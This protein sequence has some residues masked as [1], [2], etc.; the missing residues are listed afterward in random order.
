MEKPYGFMLKWYI[1][2]DSFYYASE[3]IKQIDDT[4]NRVVWEN[5]G[6]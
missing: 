5:V 3:N 6:P 4:P 1:V 2:N